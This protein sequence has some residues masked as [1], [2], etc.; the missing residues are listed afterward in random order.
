MFAYRA[1]THPLSLF[2]H[3]Q[4]A[5][6][7]IGALKDRAYPQSTMLRW[8]HLRGKPL[9]RLAPPRVIHKPTPDVPQPVVEPLQQPTA[10]GDPLDIFIKMAEIYS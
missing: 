4:P 7:Q 8:Q 9:S 5:T 3:L 6:Y 2:R 1:Y 10:L